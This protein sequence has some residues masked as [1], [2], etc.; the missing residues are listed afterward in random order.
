MIWETRAETAWNR[1]YEEAKKNFAEHGDLTVPVNYVSESGY[2]LG[3]WISDRREKSR[4]KHTEEQQRQLD[5]LGMVWQKPDTWETRYKLANAYYEEHDDL[6]IP[7]DYK[8]G[9]IWLNKWLNEQRQI[10]IGNRPGKSLEQGQIKRLET[11]GMNWDNRN[12]L[13]WNDAWEERYKAARVYFKE[14]GDLA[15]RQITITE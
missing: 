9:G 5:E 4:E 8:P 6:N 10:Y 13:L 1:G 12:C 11:I 2:K 7:A 15:D 14:H 3:R